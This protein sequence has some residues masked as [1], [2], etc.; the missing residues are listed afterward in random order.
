MLLGPLVT[1]L[2]AAEPGCREGIVPDG[3]VA[4]LELDLDGDGA[5]DR[6]RVQRGELVEATF[7]SARMKPQETSLLL[8]AYGGFEVAFPV[9]RLPRT[10]AGEQALRFVEDHAFQLI[11]TDPDPSLRR[12][13]QQQGTKRGRPMPLQWV[14]GPPQAPRWYTIRRG[15]QWVT[16]RGSFHGA[17]GQAP[18]WVARVTRGEQVLLSTQH[19]LVLTD[20]KETRHAWLYVASDG[21]GKLRHA[22]VVNP[23]FERGLAVVDR[24]DLF[25]DP[26]LR[27][28]IEV[29]L[30]TGAVSS[31]SPSQ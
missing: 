14:E 29:N 13:W 5:P 8:E 20:E 10:Q 21:I 9:L 16:Y 1:V 12:L 3:G 23:R 28:R 11:C 25:A 7:T 19:G 30:E 27:N 4:T 2:L 18:P 17:K 24:T 15:D 26:P 6:V 31:V 22:S